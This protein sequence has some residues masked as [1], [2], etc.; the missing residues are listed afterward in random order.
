MANVSPPW[1]RYDRRGAASWGLAARPPARFSSA[2]E[3][4]TTY[5]KKQPLGALRSPKTK[6]PNLFQDLAPKMTHSEFWT[7]DLW[8]AVAGVG[9]WVMF[10]MP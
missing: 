7:C 1:E 2:I 6:A 8:L 3:R 4:R 5:P 9:A 10:T